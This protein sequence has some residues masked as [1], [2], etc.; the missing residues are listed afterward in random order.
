MINGAHVV[1]FSRDAE[2]DRAFFRDVL[3]Y[4]HVD[5]GGGWLIFR[6][7]PAEVAVHPSDEPGAHELFL[8]C[9]DIASTVAELESRGVEFSRPVTEEGWGLLTTLRL[10]G[11][12][13]LRLYEPRHEVA[14][15]LRADSATPGEQPGE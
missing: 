13:E 1:V 3:G 4:P 7:P 10:P 9:D 15:S 11:G 6:L 14:H 8:M 2:A 12:G 5:A